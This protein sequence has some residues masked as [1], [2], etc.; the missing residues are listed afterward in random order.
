[1]TSNQSIGP[2]DPLRSCYTATLE[3][4][5]LLCRLVLAAALR[6]SRQ[7]E[8][9]S[10]LLAAERSCKPVSHCR[11][12]ETSLQ[13]A[14]CRRFLSPLQHTRKTFGSLTNKP[15]PVLSPPSCQLKVCVKST[16]LGFH[17]DSVRRRVHSSLIG[18]GRRLSAH[19]SSFLRLTRGHQEVG[20]EMAAAALHGH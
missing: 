16:C 6:Q 2:T 17:E 11:W 8:P 4:E 7:S 19:S 18:R 15:P 13:D 10:S 1:M 5:Q 9:V 12:T 20:Q 14:A 3:A